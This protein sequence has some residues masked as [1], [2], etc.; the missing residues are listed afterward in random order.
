M[1]AEWK[2]TSK[3]MIGACALGSCHD[4]YLGS[5]NFHYF[6]DGVAASKPRCTPLRPTN[7]N[8]AA[9]EE[10]RCETIRLPSHSEHPIPVGSS[11]LL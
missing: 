6:E 9:G 8:N 2:R 3:T 10:P 1:L 7:A 5:T 4:G 11:P